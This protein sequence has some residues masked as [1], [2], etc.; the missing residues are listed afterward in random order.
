MA[1]EHERQA[2]VT[3]PTVP[4]DTVW[5][6]LDRIATALEQMALE[7]VDARTPEAVPPHLVA[8]TAPPPLPIPAFVP[9]I[10][11]PPQPAATQTAPQQPGPFAPIGWV[12]PI[13][14][15]VRTVP[16]GVSQR[17]GKPYRAFLTC[18]ERGCDE[19][20]PR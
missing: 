13:H 12:C 17:T 10:S 8:T 6:Y 4:E 18:G 1:R 7:V 14:R 16:A 3:D 15:S 9:T 2:T 5:K 19:R 11:E 20:P